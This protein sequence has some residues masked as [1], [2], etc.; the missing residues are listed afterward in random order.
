ME[1]TACPSRTGTQNS[2]AAVRPSG[3]HQ[4]SNTCSS[5]SRA[6]T[7]ARSEYP[8][9]KLIWSVG[10]VVCGVEVFM[11]ILSLLPR[12]MAEKWPDAAQLAESVEIRRVYCWRLSTECQES[13]GNNFKNE[14]DKRAEV[15]YGS[16]PFLAGT[17]AGA[18]GSRRGRSWY[19]QPAKRKLAGSPL[20]PTWPNP[21]FGVRSCLVRLPGN[22]CH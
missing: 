5:L 4:P 6:S 18:G 16:G 15:T 13:R 17:I 11:H 20:F 8:L 12:G 21:R 2:M 14:R 1:N 9:G 7:R 22:C 10:A 19:W 3:F